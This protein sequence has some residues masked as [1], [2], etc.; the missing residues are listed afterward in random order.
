MSLARRVAA[1]PPDA[2]RMTKKLI[3]EGQQQ[4][5]ESQLELSA[6]LHAIAH[7]TADHHEAVGALLEK[8]PPRFIS[9]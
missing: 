3:R 5:L 6:A 4:S 1:K 8:R 9:S 2:L 7:H